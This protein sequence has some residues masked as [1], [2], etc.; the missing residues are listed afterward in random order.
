MTQ[1][2]LNTATNEKNITLVDIVEW[3]LKNWLKIFLS[4]IGG[5]AIGA[6]YFFFNVPYQARATIINNNGIDFVTWQNLKSNLPIL[7]SKV[8][9]NQKS[10]LVDE[11]KIYFSMRNQ[12]W[13]VNNVKP[14]FAI[15]KLDTKNMLPQSIDLRELGAT[16]ILNFVITSNAD[17]SELALKNVK[18]VSD[19]F[20]SGLAYFNIKSL[21][22]S[23]EVEVINGTANLE[24][25]ISSGI[26]NLDNLKE[27]QKSLNILVEKYENENNTNNLSPSNT[28]TTQNFIANAANNKY[29]PLNIQLIGVDI[30]IDSQ[31]LSLNI[32][33]H[34]KIEVEFLKNFVSEAFP[35]IEHDLNGID[36]VRKML[37]IIHRMR[38]NLN[39]NN[40]YAIQKSDAIQADLTAILTAATNIIDVNIPFNTTRSGLI[41]MSALGLIAGFFMSILFLLFKNAIR[42]LKKK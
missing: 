36:S 21:L 25:S 32:T 14:T 30:D 15:S 20:L 26:V 28:G 33:K 3:F 6:T 42:Q 23:Y 31:E 11:K 35:L 9:K 4:A 40:I 18:I 27:K 29:L 2:E 10:E 8:L 39:D 17:T 38:N 12:G 19:F 7:A 1:Y 5:L 37:K 16:K 34:Q 41:K 22:K 24:K 13:W